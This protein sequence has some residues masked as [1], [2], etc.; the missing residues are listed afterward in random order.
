VPLATIKDANNNTHA[1]ALKK[2]FDENKTTVP[3]DCLIDFYS[4]AH[5]NGSAVFGYFLSGYNDTP[6]GGFF[7]A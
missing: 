4:S 7:V 3:R 1:G 5:S 6:Y 2:Y